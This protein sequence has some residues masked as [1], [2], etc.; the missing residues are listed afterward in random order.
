MQWNFFILSRGLLRIQVFRA[1][2]LSAGPELIRKVRLPRKNTVGRRSLVGRPKLHVS[3]SKLHWYTS[4]PVAG[5]RRLSLNRKM[6]EL[7]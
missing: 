3:T 7:L 6:Q 5:Q 2:K 4:V 1:P